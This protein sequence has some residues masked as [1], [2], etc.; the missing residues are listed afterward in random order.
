MQNF[1][2]G[3]S[4]NSSYKM[5]FEYH[6]MD[7]RKFARFPMF[8]TKPDICWQLEWTVEDDYGRIYLLAIPNDDE[9]EMSTWKLRQGVNVN[10]CLDDLNKPTHSRAPPIYQHTAKV[11]LNIQSPFKGFKSISLSK[12]PAQILIRLFFEDVEHEAPDMKYFILAKPFPNTF[13]EAWAEKINNRKSADVQFNFANKCIYAETLMLAKRCKYFE[14]LFNQQWADK[15]TEKKKEEM[16]IATTADNVFASV[17]SSFTANTNTNLAPGIKYS[18][19]IP[20]FDYD[21][22]YEMIR[23]LYTNEIRFGKLDSSTSAIA[24][25]SISDKYLI[26]ELRR[27][28]KI[29]IWEELNEN[30]AAGILFDSAWKWDDVKEPVM[31]YIVREF[32]V[33]RKTEGFLAIESQ[34]KYNPIMGLLLFELLNKLEDYKDSIE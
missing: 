5:G 30:N 27:L 11:N 31:D 32:S 7:S 19:D 21:C 8:A 23:F 24:M 4:T 6:I 29:R 12:I 34:L 1:R 16:S 18:V 2:G 26:S 20:D 9:R 22:F 33:V 15:K 13:I 3:S 17:S 25:F 14:N 28:S 10:L